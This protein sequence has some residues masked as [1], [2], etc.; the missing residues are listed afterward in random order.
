MIKQ[1]EYVFRYLLNGRGS[2]LV[3]IISLTLGLVV[4]L[5]LY[6]QIAFEFSYDS[7]FPDR[8]PNECSAIPIR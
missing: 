3:K 2:S 6:T 8:R 4:S 7:F 5:V 1:F